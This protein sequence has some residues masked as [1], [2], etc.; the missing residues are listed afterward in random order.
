MYL[1][2]PMNAT[3]ITPPMP[4]A[5]SCF[6]KPLAN[7]VTVPVF[8][9]TREILPAMVSVTYKALLEPDGACP[10]PPCTA[11]VISRVAVGP[12]GGIFPASALPPPRMITQLKARELLLNLSC[13]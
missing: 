9:S 13:S 6:G 3:S 4:T 7:V 11:R 2:S 12:A 8:G 5:T 10:M 1:V